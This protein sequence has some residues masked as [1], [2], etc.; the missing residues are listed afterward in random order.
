ME[1]IKYAV[2]SIAHCLQVGA[3]IVRGMSCEEMD[4]L[5]TRKKIVG[6]GYNA[7]PDGCDESKLPDWNN[8]DIDKHGWMGTKYP[9]G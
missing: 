3:V 1:C 6:I 2:I 8:S 5:H 4:K 7:M 9:Y